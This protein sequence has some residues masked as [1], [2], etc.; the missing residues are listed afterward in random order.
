VRDVPG[1]GWA[2]FSPALPDGTEVRAGQL[3]LDNSLVTLEVDPTNGTLSVN[4][5]AGLDLLVDGGDEGD[6]YNYCPPRS[7]TLIDRPDSV[8][9]ELVE[10]GPVRGLLE[11]TRRF[12]WPAAALGGRRIGREIVDVVSLVELRAGEQLVRVTTRFDN[13]CRDH[14]LRARFPLPHA[15][16]RTVAECA[17]STVTR[18]APEGGPKE[19]PVAT[20]PSRRFVSAGGLTITHEGLLEYELVDGGTALAVT[21][22]RSTGM[23]SR[24]A[25]ATR[26]NA[27]GPAD[28]LEA[29]QLLGP[30]RVRYAV[31]V[32]AVDPWR[33][34]DMAW[35]PLHVVAAS[36]TGHLAPTGSRLTVRGAEVSALHRVDGV[37][38]LRLFNPGGE[39]ARVEVPGHSGWL[40]DLRG[41]PVERWEG[42]FALRPWGIATV[43]LDAAALDP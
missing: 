3:G 14:R 5:L 26:P 11:I 1:F 18:G 12:G 20:F 15:T 25:P 30:H 43:H 17:F 39:V 24:P 38:E 9:V 21:L 31:A 6:T 10:A 32:A 41:Q 35:L 22:L 23:L 4:G 16:D 29:P 33:L 42:E 13:R 8:D 27:A 7:D 19:P 28:P 36:G 40:V 2:A 34:A 37:I